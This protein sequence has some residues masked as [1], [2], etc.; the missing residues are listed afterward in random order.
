[1]A[2]ALLN[3]SVDG[4]QAQSGTLAG[5]LGG[6][7]GIENM[8]LGFRVHAQAVVDHRNLDIRTGLELS[9]RRAKVS[10]K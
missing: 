7:E 9:G 1:M 5:L 3:D 6:K 8:S 2:A 10:F 4:G